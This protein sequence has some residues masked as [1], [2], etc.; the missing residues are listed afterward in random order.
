M[1]S[2]FFGSGNLVFPLAIGYA[3][4]EHFLSAGIGLLITGTLVPLLGL[5]ALIFSNGSRAVFFQSLGKGPAFMVT[6]LILSILGPFGVCARCVLVSYGSLELIFPSLSLSLFSGLFC[7][8]AALMTLNR[9][10]IVRLIGRY[11]T[12]FLLFGILL[13]LIVGIYYAS[14]VRPSA[15]TSAQAFHTGLH[16]GYQTMDLLAAFFFS[17]TVI[18]FLKSH[19]G[20]KSPPS[21]IAREAVKASLV[22][23]TLLGLIY[24]G[25]VSLGASYAPFLDGHHSENMLVLIAQHT[26]GS[27]ALPIIAVTIMLACLTTLI[28][29][30]SLFADFFQKDVCRQKVS[31]PLSVVVTYGLCF[32]MSL[33]GFEKLVA[34][35]GGILEVIY[36]A[37]I[38]F[39]LMTITDAVLKKRWAPKIFYIVL[40]FSGAMAIHLL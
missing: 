8:A 12:P 34:F 3:T 31:R 29:L 27:M 18:D 38:A 20:R 5:F 25:F 13:I 9:H 19:L 14:P 1:F 10:R 16:Q 33:M 17:A 32:G 28:I 11:L 7:V 15:L 26:L 39:S 37:L 30:A 6:F 40:L 2:M 35:I 22:G 23:M 36:P 21:L 4:L 24:I